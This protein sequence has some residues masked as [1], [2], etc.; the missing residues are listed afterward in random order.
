MKISRIL[1]ANAK[2][3]LGLHVLSKRQDDYHN[4]ESIFFP[5]SLHDIIKIRLNS[6]NYGKNNIIAETNDNLLT[7]SKSNLAYKAAELF[8]KKFK[9]HGFDLYI[10]IDKHIPIGGGLGGGSSDAAAVLKFLFTAFKFTDK[11]FNQLKKI[12]LSLG[13]DVP[14]F[15]YNCPAYVYSKGEK[16]KLLK[17]FKIPYDILIVNPAIHVST[18]WAY[19]SLNIKGTKPKTLNRINILDLD[20]QEYFSNDFEKPVFKKY[21]AIKKIKEDMAELGAEFCSMSGS[22]ST[23]YGFFNN[24]NIKKAVSYFTA[25]KYSVFVSKNPS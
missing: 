9:L 25:K 11:K 2:I 19:K 24:K 5:V 4:I 10:N 7:D 22:G 23:V 12:A 17:D 20:K 6:N 15:L 14:Y 13:S 21:P 1:K 18:P 8:F 3:N 16:L